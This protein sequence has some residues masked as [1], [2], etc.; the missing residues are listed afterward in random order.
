MIKILIVDDSR[1]FR[2]RLKVFL[3][4]YP[5]VSVVG[6]AWEGQAAL[7]K[8][9]ELKPDLVLMDVKM[10]DTNGLDV[11]M[12]LKGEFPDIKVIILSIYELEAYRRAA[13][14]VG[15]SAYVTKKE[16]VDEL[17]PAIRLVMQINQS[18]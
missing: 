12:R 17:I 15:A 8:A 7:I 3:V 5:E 10:G 11:T 4:E 18:E 2:E 1:L 6:E 14:T 9:R 16:L 13:E